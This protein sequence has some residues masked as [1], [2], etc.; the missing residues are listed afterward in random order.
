RIGKLGPGSLS[1]LRGQRGHRRAVMGG[2]IPTRLRRRLDNEEHAVERGM[3]RRRNRRRRLLPD[4]RVDA[5]GDRIDLALGPGPSEIPTIALAM[6]DIGYG[7]FGDTCP[8]C[9]GPLLRTAAGRLG[10]GE[11]VPPRAVGGTVS[12]TTC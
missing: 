5:F 11:D 8:L 3:R 2:G 10:T 7:D 1:F 9:T 4:G 12:T 6:C